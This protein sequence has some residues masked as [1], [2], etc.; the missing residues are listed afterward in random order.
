MKVQKEKYGNA[1]PKIEQDDI[2]GGD[3]GV[4]TIAAVE[5]QKV[6]GDDGERISL[7]IITEELGDK[8]HWL[9]VTQIG[10]LIARLGD[11]TEDWIG[12][13]FPLV[14]TTTHYAGKPFK[15]VWVAADAEWDEI[16]EAA[17]VS[18]RKRVARRTVKAVKAVRRAKKK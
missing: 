7:V 1:K 10:Y 15:K 8:L 12:E 4:F 5:E 3:A 16:F 6:S 14:K 2:E 13:K 18:S 17:G 11:N 9:N